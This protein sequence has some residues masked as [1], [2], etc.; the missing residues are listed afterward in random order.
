MGALTESLKRAIDI[1]RY[2][3][4]YIDN[5]I[6]LDTVPKHEVCCP[7]HKENTPSFT[8]SSNKHLWRCW[9]ECKVGGDVIALH[10]KNYKLRTREEAEK[11]LATILHI[12]DISI[13]FDTKD[14]KLDEKHIEYASSYNTAIRLAV[15]VQDWLDLD[16]I[17][18]QNKSYTELKEDLDNFIQV[19]K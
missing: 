19:R 3:K 18:S 15:K 17:M 14:P 11:S 6:D 10:Q 2:Y 5:N 4:E 9:G 12:D 7:F 13:D 1:P 16:Y 8:Y